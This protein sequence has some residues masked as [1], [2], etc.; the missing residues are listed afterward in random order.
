MI[1]NHNIAA[2][3]TLNQL[4]KNTNATQKS[5]EKLSSGL[6]INSAAD[7][8]AGLAISEK[9]KGQIRGLDQATRNSQDGISLL[10]TAEGALNETQDILQRIRELAVQ[11]SNGTTTD[12]DRTSIQDEVNQLSS[13]V[14][15][16]GNTTEFNTQKLLNGGIDSNSGAIIT[17]ATNA[18]KTLATSVTTAAPLAFAAGDKIVVDDV[19]FNLDG[20]AVDGKTY[21]AAS[22][23]A[24]ALKNLTSGGV[25]LSDVAD[26]SVDGAGKLTV[27]SKSTGPSSN[28]D[29][30]SAATTLST[31]ANVSA[32]AIGK[33]TTVERAGIQATN[34]LGASADNVIAANSTFTIQVGSESAVT[35]TLKNGKT[36]D[37]QNTDANV[38]KA[39]SQD[40]I[41][42]LNAALQ[43]AGISDKVTASL[44]DNNEV[45]FISETGKDIKLTEGTGT[46]LSSIGFDPVA[47]G[48]A[49]T[50]T[51]ANVQQ[52]VGAGAQGTG[53]NTSFQ[54]GANKGQS[55][56]ININD[57]RSAALGI[58]GNSGQAGF[59]AANSV[60]NGTDDVQVEAALNVSNKDD[61]SKAIAVIDAATAKVS[62]ERGKLG[63]YENRLDHTINNL[64]ASSQNLTAAQSRITD[65]D[66]A[67]EMSNFTKN[68]ILNQA[69][70]AMLA[71]ANQ[72]PQGVLQLL[73]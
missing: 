51:I 68:N 39:A 20:S 35:V 40:L 28:V 58:T 45:Q 11:S 17:Q 10:Q 62:A 2:L 53:F 56:A 48:A 7:D 8:A 14:N 43:D 34:A 72:L 49:T 25:K 15:R 22:D 19:T 46:P 18:S 73:R 12:A 9:M 16:I 4:S 26:V 29:I 1:I 50:E 24:D 3:N 42:D 36:Y 23:V 21:A 57:M 13:E 5:L 30:V 41:K 54:I 55:I 37:T 67:A 66:M 52:V 44:S 31:A 69:A 60:T 63:A 27:T 6:R 33:S 38:A 59:T 65:V 64:S 32:V 70:Q 61:A 47:S 71:Q